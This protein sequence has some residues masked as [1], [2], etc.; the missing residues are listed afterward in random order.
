MNDIEFAIY[1]LQEA[2]QEAK[3]VKAYEKDYGECHFFVEGEREKF[4]RKWPR[5][6]CRSVV[7]DN[8]KMARRLL[9]RGY[10]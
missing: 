2:A 8:I 1:L 10:M 6:P 5:K 4:L 3:L 7:N 9:L